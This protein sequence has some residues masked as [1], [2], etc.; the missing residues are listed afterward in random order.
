MTVTKKVHIIIELNDEETRMLAYILK[1]ISELKNSNGTS[2]MPHVTEFCTRLR[3][4][5][6]RDAQ[7]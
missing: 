5:L 4:N 7:P 6:P 2:V 1:E 3:L